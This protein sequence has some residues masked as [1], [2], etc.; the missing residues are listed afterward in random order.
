MHIAIIANP[1]A[2][3]LRARRTCALVQSY[4][5]SRDIPF[6]Y[7]ETE[8][9]GHAIAL[10]RKAAKTHTIVAGLG[11]DGTIREVLEGVW[12]TN[13]VLGVLPAGT[14][15]DHARSLGIPRDPKAATAVLIEGRAVP[16]DVGRERDYIFGCVGAV[17]FPV[18]VMDN[19]NNS[20]L[21][22][23]V[24]KLAYLGAIA[25]TLQHLR[26]HPL[27]ITIDGRR[28]Q[29]DSVGVLV[30]NMPYA[31]GGLMFA[32]KAKY[33]DGLFSVVIVGKVGRLD[34]IRTLPKVY[35]GNHVGHPQI[36]IIQGCSVTIEPGGFKK[37][38]DG[39]LGGETPF[40]ARIE[41]S[42]ARV[43]IPP[44]GGMSS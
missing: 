5:K 39:D 1:L 30:M 23:T 21:G 31:G 13:A 29:R 43:M 19:L 44:R 8:Y 3:R 37:L 17:G 33:N 24:G 38:F 35:K 28:I 40:R 18:D 4:L 34:L 16:M 2:G 25:K 26:P 20:P 36:E 14:G 27:T 7:Y 41:A 11:G 6:S 10:A 9:A 22:R 32:P 12:N 42:A 15:N